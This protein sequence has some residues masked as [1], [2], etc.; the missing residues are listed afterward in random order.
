MQISDETVDGVLLLAIEGQINGNNATSLEQNLCVHLDKAA[1]RI[2]LDFSGVDYISSAGLR[3]VLWLAKRLEDHAGALALF[4]LRKN[5]LEIFEMCGFTDMLPIVE[6]RK[7]ALEK[8]KS[9]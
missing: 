5:V 9:A 2:A 3:V 6:N 4:G 1:Y 8:I 7:A